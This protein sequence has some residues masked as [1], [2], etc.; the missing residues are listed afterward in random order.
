MNA[1][2]KLWQ[3]KW[4]YCYRGQTSWICHLAGYFRKAKLGF[5]F[6]Q[7]PYY[8]RKKKNF[9]LFYCQW[10]NT[11]LQLLFA[12]SRNFYHRQRSL[13][14]VCRKSNIRLNCAIRR[15]SGV[16]NLLHAKTVVCEPLKFNF[17]TFSVSSIPT[18]YRCLIWILY[19]FSDSSTD[20]QISLENRKQLLERAVQTE[21]T[22]IAPES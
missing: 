3:T 16:L 10:S 19:Y 13:I 15:L 11:S 20:M 5:E 9:W 21:E 6:Q 1:I 22:R 18:L 8:V 17:H 14:I 7:R 4:L 12:N 2:K